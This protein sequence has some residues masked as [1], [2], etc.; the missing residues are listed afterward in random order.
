MLIVPGPI[1]MLMVSLI[2]IW[3]HPID[4]NRRKELKERLYDLR[5][6][7]SF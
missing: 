4:E 1:V 2:F 7:Q 3:K 6:N 5:H